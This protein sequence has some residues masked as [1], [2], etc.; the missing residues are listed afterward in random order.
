MQAIVL[1]G[2][3]RFRLKEAVHP[4]TPGSGE[5]LV[6]VHRVGICGSDLHAFKGSH[7]FLSYPRVLGHEIGVEIVAVGRNEF[8]LTVGDLCAVEPYLNCGQCTVCR[9][10]RPNC[11]INLQVLGTHRDGG[12]Q[13]FMIVPTAK[14]HGSHKLSLEQLALVEM[15]SIGA[16]AVRRAQ[17]G[18]SESVLVLGAGPIGLSIVFFA[19]SVGARVVVVEPNEKRREFCGRHFRVEECLEGK[20]NQAQQLRTA[21]GGDLPTAVF[22]ATGSA[23]SMMQAPH[24]LANGGKLIFVSLVQADLTFADPLFHRLEL[25]LLCCRNAT[26]QDFAWAIQ[27]LEED[28]VNITPWITHRAERGHVIQE[29]SRWLDPSQGVIKAMV[30]I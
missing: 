30:E 2:P 12:M 1:E 28:K 11:C 29:F 25:T 17:L 26:R 24:Y 22:D 14:L 4:G 20:G 9:R 13:E 10:E 18:K 16:H 21:F 8:G 15:L 6:R 3:G 5:A 19:Q 23:E 7:P 27:E